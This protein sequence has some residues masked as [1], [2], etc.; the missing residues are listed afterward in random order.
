MDASS[1]FAGMSR[2]RYPQLIKLVSLQYHL[3]DDAALLRNTL[4]R[5]NSTS[6][7]GRVITLSIFFFLAFM[8]LGRVAYLHGQLTLD[9][10]ASYRIQRCV[11][12]GSAVRTTRQWRAHV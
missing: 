11:H 2:T 12:V 9:S 5:R 6:L 10:S 8:M 4:G 7:W 3:K 1:C